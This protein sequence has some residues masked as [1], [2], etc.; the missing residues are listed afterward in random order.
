MTTKTTLT[1]MQGTIS[2]SRTLSIVVK[3]GFISSFGVELF[4][5]FAM[6]LAGG[7][8][9]RRF[10]H[11]LLASISW[12]MTFSATI[13]SLAES[14]EIRISTAYMAFSPA[15]VEAEVGDRITWINDSG[16]KHEI[17]FSVNPT[18]SGPRRLDHVLSGNGGELSITVSK[19]GEYDY[20]CR[21]HGMH[22]S[23]RVTRK[24][25]N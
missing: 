6:G 8:S 19:P 10:L 5:R 7:R 14:R 9:W 20:F 22:G 15:S 3:Q 13:P 23:I 4:Q 18:N 24:S 16:V 21:W 25:L 2:T 17:Y 11:F 1:A 12:S